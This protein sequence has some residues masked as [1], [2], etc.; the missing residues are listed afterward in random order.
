LSKNKVAVGKVFISFIIGSRWE[1]MVT[2]LVHLNRRL[3]KKKI[4]THSMTG[5]IVSVPG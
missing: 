5:S 4:S 3:F 1:V 2:E